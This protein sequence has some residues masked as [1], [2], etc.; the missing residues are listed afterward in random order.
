MSVP[1][2]RTGI[3]FYHQ[4]G[5]RLRDFPGAL[6]GILNKENVFFYDAYYP[7]KPPSSFEMETLSPEM[8]YRIHSSEMVDEIKR[9]GNFEGAVFS[10]A[11][12]VR[13]AE[14]IWSGE[15]DNAFVFTGYGDHHAGRTF[16]GGGCYFNGA[17]LAIDNLRKRFGARRFTIVDTD[18]HHGN[19][20][21]D[22]FEADQD[23]LYVCFCENPYLEKN[24]KVNIEVP[25]KVTDAE[26][27][28]LVKEAF[29]HRAQAFQPEM[30]FWNWGFD[31]TRGEY[32]DIG[33]T[34]DSHISLALELKAMADKLCQG[35]L[36]TVLCG[37]RRRDL[38]SRLCP[39]II[40]V[41]A[42][43]DD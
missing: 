31:G 17:A 32:G 40:K 43:G 38:A 8:L 18:A 2:R 15:I 23:L 41:M 35:K 10:A 22:I 16:F 33:L 9:T 24:N 6:E 20:T 29:F 25:N 36:V 28:R 4:T 13:A 27:L 3:F 37:G 39:S 1:T 14:K 34:P 11:A 12:T 26:Y 30:L 7:S 5:E 42:G 21:W 19:G